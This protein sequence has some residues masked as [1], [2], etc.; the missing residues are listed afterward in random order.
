MLCPETWVVEK[1]KDGISRPNCKGDPEW[2]KH[3]LE[4]K[5]NDKSVI[6]EVTDGAG[7][8]T[9]LKVKRDMKKLPKK[10]VK[11]ML[12]FVKEKLANSIDLDTDEEEFAQIHDL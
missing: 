9:K 2:M 6:D 10:E 3:A 8:V 12:E 1:D 11:K 7:N 5:V 4:T